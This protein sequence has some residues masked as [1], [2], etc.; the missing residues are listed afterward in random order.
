MFWRLALLFVLL[1]TL[2]LL[3]LW[4]F[5]SV[6]GLLTTLLLVVGTG[7]FG[8]LLAKRQG[9]HC[10]LE[11]NRQLDYGETPTLPIMNGILVFLAA[12]LLII[13]GIITDVFGLLLL[14]PPVRRLVISH[15]L[16]RFEAYRAQTR[17]RQAP[18][19]PDV[20]DIE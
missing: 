1:P 2:D 13:P 18:K 6:F 20:I 3:G 8:V 5:S 10:W 4:F 19:D 11:L 9:L 15:I 16:L 14:I 12:G 7:I 17:R